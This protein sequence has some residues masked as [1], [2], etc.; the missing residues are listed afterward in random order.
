MY[1]VAVMRTVLL[2]SASILLLS[3][4]LVGQNTPMQCSGIRVVGPDKLTTAGDDIVFTAQLVGDL[5]PSPIK[6]NW[7]IS[8]GTMKSGQGS[9]SIVVQTT[10]KDAGANITATVEIGPCG[11]RDYV[12]SSA[13]ASVARVDCRLP[14]DQYGKARWLDEMARLDNFWIQLK[15]DPKVIGIFYIRL[16]SGETIDTTKKHILK[17][18]KHF[19]WRDKEFDLGRLRF[20]VLE[21]ADHHSTTLLAFP[22]G[23]EM[24]TCDNTEC[25]LF[26]GKDFRP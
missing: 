11:P 25:S 13:T 15:S 6:Y 4:T 7:T 26:S 16:E 12:V 8:S 23:A 24:L 1:Y 17:I 10:T 9:P 21:G 2:A 19:K 14:L 3:L 5:A 22:E 18:L 20:L